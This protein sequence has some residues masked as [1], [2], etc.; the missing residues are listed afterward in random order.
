MTPTHTR[1]AARFI[2]FIKFMGE[3]SFYHTVIIFLFYQKLIN[4]S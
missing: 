1:G 3:R 2:R 4:I